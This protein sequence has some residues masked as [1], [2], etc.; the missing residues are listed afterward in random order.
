MRIRE[1]LMVFAMGA[2]SLC[3]AEFT[4]K[5]GKFE[6]T[7][8]IKAVAVPESA[9]EISISPKAWYDYPV[10]SLAEH[11]RKVK[12]GDTLIQVDTEKLDQAILEAEKARLVD[13]MNLE[14]LKQEL[15]E[16]EVN[17]KI[18][19][20][21]AQ[22][23]YERQKQDYEY[24]KNTELPLMEADAKLT[25]DKYQWRLDN[26][27]EELEQLLKMYKADGLTEETE[28]IIVQRAKNSVKASE[29]DYKES[30]L[31]GKRKLEVVIP[32]LKKD[33]EVGMQRETNK[34]ESLQ[35]SWPRALE[36]K[37]AEVEKAVRADQ[38]KAEH[39][40]KLKAD[41]KAAELV[42]P[43]DGYVYYGEFIPGGW[44]QDAARKV[45]FKGG[46]LPGDKVLMTVVP[47]GAKFELEGKANEWQ[48]NRLTENLSGMASPAYDPWKRFEVKVSDVTPV[49]QKS[50]EWVIEFNSE[51]MADSIVAGS[52]V[53]LSFKSYVNEKA[54]FVPPAAVTSLPDGSYTVNV[55]MADGK[56]EAKTIKVG[57][58]TS[59]KVEVVEGLEAGQ[60]VIY[61]E[62]K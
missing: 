51:Q 50:G 16:L 26:E 6:Q 46:K 2:A 42:S 45:L 8:D 17:T 31:A 12:K 60:V 5:E 24:F 15:A 38:R 10:D 19:L 25:M 23:N 34:W 1:S 48:V 57:Q 27:K 62:K 30:M 56:T 20:D 4:L 22:R 35:K 29:F 52:S 11:G 18:S 61:E 55:K 7:V 13:Q 59:D 21:E 49:P 9:A 53:D 40:D 39:L 54:L 28:E 43:V 41:R 3:A 32:R 36:I 37:R 58:V 44:Y 33:R 14:K 47:E